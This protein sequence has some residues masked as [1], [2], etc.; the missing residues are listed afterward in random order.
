MKEAI[1]ML[2]AGAGALAVVGAGGCG[3]SA[4]PLAAPD[5][6]VPAAAR[7]VRPVPDTV[8]VGDSVVPGPDAGQPGH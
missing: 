2:L 1:R 7:P 5:R 4:P 6:A 8:T 3:G